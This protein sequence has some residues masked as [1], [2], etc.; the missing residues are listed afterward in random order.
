[1]SYIKNE[2]VIGE[3]IELEAKPHKIRWLNVILISSVASLMAAACLAMR[4]VPEIVVDFRNYIVALFFVIWGAYSFFNLFLSE[5]VVT[6]RRVVFKTG[7][8]R[9]TIKEMALFKVDSVEIRQ[10]FLGRIFN[11]GTVCFLGSGVTRKQFFSSD[12]R[13]PKDRDMCIK[14]V[15]VTNPKVIK[16][17]VD[18]LIDMVV[19]K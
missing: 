4:Y 12:M 18:I 14:F 8:I 5:M 16:N 3:Y 19:G 6:N 9:S 13:N 17:Q 15:K 2:L 10:S 11:Y 7:L 1:M